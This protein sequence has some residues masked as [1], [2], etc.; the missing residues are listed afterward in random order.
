MFS[1]SFHIATS[2][3]FPKHNAVFMLCTFLIKLWV[4]VD[5]LFLKAESH[6]YKIKILETPS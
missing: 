5:K 2:P 3:P 1:F 4:M 6:T